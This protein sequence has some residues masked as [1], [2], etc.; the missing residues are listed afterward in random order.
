MGEV[1]TPDLPVLLWKFRVHAIWVQC[2]RVSPI[3]FRC[4]RNDFQPSRLADCE[5]F[6]QF[7]LHRRFF[8]CHCSL[9][10]SNRNGERRAQ[11]LLI[12]V[13]DN[14][15]NELECAVVFTVMAG[16]RQSAL[17]S[18]FSASAKYS[19]NSCCVASTLSSA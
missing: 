6:F 12:C 3:H 7:H 18:F 4:F 17:L 19:R 8:H 10:C 16:V 11:A 13:C 2:L 1:F 5:P 15:A 14:D 9:P